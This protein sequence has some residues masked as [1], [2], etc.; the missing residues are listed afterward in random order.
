[1]TVVAGAAVEPPARIKLYSTCPQSRGLD[2]AVYRKRVVEVARWGEAAGCEGI[3]VYTD[4]AIVDPWLVAQLIIGA[5][6]HIAP[7]VAVQPMYMHPYTVAKM[8]SSLGYLHR[9]RV[10]VNL[11]AGGFRNDLEALGDGSP[12]DERYSRALEY[13]QVIS[14]LVAGS[15]FSF[16]GSHY[17]VSN[18]RLTPPVPADR[19]PSLTISGSSEAGMAA[20]RE[21][22]ATAIKY[23]RP[24]HQELA[25]H[26]QGVEIGMRIGVIA[27][28]HAAEAWR[29]A[30][31]RFPV[32]RAGQLTQRLAA[33]VSDSAWHR[34]LTSLVAEQT[35]GSDVN[36]LGP[37][38]NYASF[39][40]YLVGDHETVAAELARYLSLGFSTFLL[41]IP[42]AEEDLQHA[43]LTLRQATTPPA[44]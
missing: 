4:N 30:H 41:D 8:I 37:F 1:M 40:P 24:S 33:R 23:P 11:V 25:H 29:V 35:G 44:L 34:Q 22:G 2:P 10:D 5:T 14:G 38:E 32:D 42:Q 21:L 17:R 39:C 27:R 19:R 36:W 9:R 18:L 26:D 20:A 16:E 12:H 28:E 6:Q 7:L 13:A 15:A 43:A 3:L 31:A